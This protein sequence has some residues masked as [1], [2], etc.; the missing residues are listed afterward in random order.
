[1]TTFHEKYPNFESNDVNYAPKTST[2]N[3]VKAITSPQT[4]K[5]VAT[6]GASD[7]E[8]DQQAKRMRQVVI[9]SDDDEEEEVEAV[10]PTPAEY[11][12]GGSPR[13]RTPAILARNRRAVDPNEWKQHIGEHDAATPVQLVVRLENGERKTIRLV[14]STKLKAIFLFIG[15]LGLAMH[16]HLLVLNHPKRVFSFNEQEKTLAEAGFGPQEVIYLERI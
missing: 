14:D 6:D 12:L 1:M 10:E 2:S 8:T 7:S 15:G 11:R 9:I 3:P 13:K 5:R 16:E 4:Q